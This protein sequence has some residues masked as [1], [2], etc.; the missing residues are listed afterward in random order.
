M[1]FRPV[2]LVTF[3]NFLFRLSFFLFY[4]FFKYFFRFIVDEEYNIPSLQLGL[5]YL[6][7]LGR[8]NKDINL[9]LLLCMLCVV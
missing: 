6:M 5:I 7:K 1:G 3:L 8:P 4:Y 9:S 2:G